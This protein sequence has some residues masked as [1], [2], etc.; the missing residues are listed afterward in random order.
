MS[1]CCQSTA[2]AGLRD[3][4]ALLL[5]LGLSG[6]VAGCQ[7]PW[8]VQGV[9][10]EAGTA[11]G[12]GV[13]SVDGVPNPFQPAGTTAIDGAKVTFECPGGAMK[14]T[15]TTTFN[16]QFYFKGH[17]MDFPR[18]CTLRVEVPGRPPFMGSFATIPCQTHT[19]TTCRRAVIAVALAK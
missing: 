5:G 17:G 1:S 15:T 6:A 13:K 3:A 12:A 11:M 14:E 19:P 4:G 2:F 8:S 18:A 16:G 7:P 9:V 10:V